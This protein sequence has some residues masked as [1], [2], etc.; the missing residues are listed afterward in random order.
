VKGKWRLDRWQREDNG[1]TYVLFSG[2]DLALHR[3]AMPCD[4]QHWQDLLR[5]IAS[6]VPFTFSLYSD[7]GKFSD[8]SLKSKKKIKLSSFS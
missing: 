6:T 3:I 7:T 2:L 4:Q 1:F 8:L 5:I